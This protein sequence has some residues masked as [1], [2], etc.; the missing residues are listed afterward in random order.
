MRAMC[1][2]PYPSIERQ[3]RALRDEPGMP[4]W[5]IEHYVAWL[6]AINETLFWI[7]VRH[8]QGRIENG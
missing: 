2:G 1:S 3:A 5:P 7:Y 8:L 4:D 6:E